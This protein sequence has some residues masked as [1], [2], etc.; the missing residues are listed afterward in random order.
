MTSHATVE[1]VLHTV[2]A[3][4]PVDRGTLV[5]LLEQRPSPDAVARLLAAP[6]VEVVTAALT[7][8][9]VFG[10]PRHRPAL[11]RC[12]RHPDA[13]VARVAEQALWMLSMRGGSPRGNDRLAAAIRRIEESDFAPATRL[14]ADLLADEPDFAEA[15]FQLGVALSLLDRHGESAAA[16]RAA[17]RLNPYHFGAAEG[18]GHAQVELGDYAA[19]LRCYRLA[20]RIH[21]RLP[22]LAT[23]VHELERLVPAADRPAPPTR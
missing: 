11:G 1:Q 2:A 22:N 16:H 21:P 9:A 3:D 8:L 13:N 17:L 5:S 19:A 12:L 18:L 14:L 15:H 20:L 4:V 23:A 10:T 7:Y 6:A